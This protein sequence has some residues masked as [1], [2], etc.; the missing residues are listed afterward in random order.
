MVAEMPSN[1]LAHV[2]KVVVPDSAPLYDAMKSA[3]VRLL[4][5]EPSLGIKA[6]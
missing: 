1:R 3:V 5:T 4:I 6:E 2:L